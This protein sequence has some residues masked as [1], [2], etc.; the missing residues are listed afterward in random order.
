MTVAAEARLIAPHGG[1]LVDRTG[2]RPADLDSLE[3]LTLSPREVSDL[4]MLACGALSPL[5]GFMGEEDYER[6][7]EDMHLANGLRGR[8]P[9][10]WPYRLRQAGTASPWPTATAALSRCSK[11]TRSSSTTSGARPSGASA[12]RTSSIRE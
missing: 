8:C 11:S 3:T 7:V 9:S 6:V 4:D 1:E 12:P 2:E 5:E 10:A